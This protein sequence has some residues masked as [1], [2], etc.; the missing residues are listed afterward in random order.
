MDQTYIIKR[1]EAF[2]LDFGSRR[3]GSLLLVYG[4]KLLG[5]LVY[6]RR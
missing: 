3:L 6:V 5:C 1:R 2:L 4:A